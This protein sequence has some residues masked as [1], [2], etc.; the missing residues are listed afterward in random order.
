LV[1]DQWLPPNFTT[2]LTDHSGYADVYNAVNNTKGWLYDT[3]GKQWFP[4]YRV[5]L[6]NGATVDALTDVYI[7]LLKTH[8]F[9][10]I[11]LDCCHTSI[12]WTSKSDRPLAPPIPGDTLVAMDARR[13]KNITRMIRRIRKAGDGA[14][15]IA[16]NG[17]GPRP[18]GVD[19]DFREGYGSLITHDQAV[20]WLKTPG[21]HWL[22][23]SDGR[24]E[25]DLRALSSMNKKTIISCGV[26]RDWPP[27]PCIY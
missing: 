16:L 8:L 6:S 1:G 25:T 12:A 18:A 22:M 7:S 10:G 27:Y 14:T 3:E 11:F 13:L 17:T 4:N 21:W 26:D 5:D 19:I 24:N 2:S 23:S 15:K 9:N 20:E